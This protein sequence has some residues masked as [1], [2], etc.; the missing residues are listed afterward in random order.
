MS[1]Q[2]FRRD[3]RAKEPVVTKTLDDVGVFLS[4]L[5]GETPSP[6]HRGRKNATSSLFTRTVNT[7]TRTCS[8]INPQISAQRSVPKMW[9]GSCAKKQM[10][11]WPSGTGSAPNQVT[12]RGGWS[13]LWI[14]WW[15]SRRRRICWTDSWGRPRWWRRRGNLLVTCWSTRCQRT[16]TKSRSDWETCSRHNSFGL[17]VVFASSKWDHGWKDSCLL[18]ELGGTVFFFQ[19]LLKVSIWI[20][21][22]SFW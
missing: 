3:L 15:S 2:G 12:G 5:P 14:G 17:L 22:E 1:S 4:E 18:L 13:W 19:F 11:W 8:L 21:A 20:L 16:S 9:G 10:T 6:E 7:V